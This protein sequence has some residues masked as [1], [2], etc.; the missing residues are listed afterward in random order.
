[1]R[2]CAT[3]FFLLMAFCALAQEKKAPS[4]ELGAGISSGKYMPFWL[5]ANQYGAVPTKES[6]AT[7]AVSFSDFVQVNKRAS[8]G[9]GV[10]ALVNLAETR[11]DVLLQEAY[12]NG[13]FGIFELQAGRKKQLQ[14][15]MDSTLSSGSIIWSGNALPM[16]MINLVVQDYWAPKFVQGIVGFKGNYAHGWFDNQRSDVSNFYLHQK[17]FYGRLGKPNGLFKFYGGFNHQVQWGGKLKYADPGNFSAKNGKIASSPKDYFYIITGQ[18]MNVVG[19]DTATYGINDGWN[20]L[21]NHLGTID[22]GMEIDWKKAKLFLYRQSIY[23][24]GSLYYGNNIT[25][26]LHGVAFTQKADQGIIKVVIEYLNTTSQG[27]SVFNGSSVFRGLDNYFNNAVYRDGWTYNGMGLGTPM[28]TLDSETDLTNTDGTF[29][30]NNRVESFYMGVEAKLGE[31]AFML[32]GSMSNSIGWF[33]QE[34]IPAKKQY[35][36]GLQWQRPLQLMGYNTQLKATLGADRGSWKPDV[37]GGNVSL[38]V[39]LN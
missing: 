29:Y 37:I 17:S 39:P 16:P 13:R 18:S 8:W 19:G 36:V 23:E 33:G 31:N 6:Y 26:G 2:L 4:F 22:V 14:G 5:R 27:G 32:R 28:L 35:S 24:D 20:R 30:D 25:D 10:R 12:L 34:N 11:A 3:F 7:A 1:M 15:L 38:I 21:G 9:Y